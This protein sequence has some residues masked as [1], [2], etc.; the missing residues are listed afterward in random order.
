MIS[1]LLKALA[2]AVS[3]CLLV[4]IMMTLIE[5]FNVTTKGRV[6][7]GLERHPR[8]QIVIAALLGLIPGC[9]GGF[10]GVSLYSH[11]MIGFGALLAM[12]TA[13]TGDETFL[14]LSMFP[15]KAVQIYAGLFC[16]ALVTGFTA[17]AVTRA[18]N[19]K[20]VPPSLDGDLNADDNYELHTCD[21]DGHGHGENREEGGWKHEA[22]HFLKEHVWGHVI[23]RHL[24]SIF[25]WTFGVLAV[26]GILSMYIDI[27]TWIQGNTA[28]MI[29][30]AVLV[31]LIPESGPHMIFITMFA[32]GVLPFP[33]LLANTITQ[34]GHACL[35]LLA[36]NRKSFIC[37]KAIKACIALAAGFIAMLF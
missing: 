12:L 15:G 34:D 9:M 2:E 29:F 33:V 28:L 26:F 27:G 20:A 32:S 17:D 1:V 13:T 24:P 19:G 31:G 7:N 3:I 11:R 21:C 37:A 14:M 8:G 5:L 36:E 6:F 23:K 10:A 35:P 16:L 22:V 18:L 30:I 25:L 4:M